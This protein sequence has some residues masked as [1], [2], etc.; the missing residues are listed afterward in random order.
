MWLDKVKKA[1]GDNLN[2]TWKNFSLEQNAHNLKEG[3]DSDWKVWEQ[4][5]ASERR[6][7][8]SQIAAEAAR[9]QGE[10]AHA[11]FHLALLVARH[12]GEGRISLSDE[13]AIL[14]LAESVGLDSAQM[15]EDMKDP[16]LRR[17]IGEEHEAAISE[18]IFGTPTYVFENGNMAYLKAFIPDDEDAVASFEHYIALANHRNYFGEIKRP[19][20]PW[21][22]G[23]LS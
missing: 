4:E 15:R 23:V 13:D 2:I 22:K 17:K 19:Q 14:E 6:S 21:P 11:K 1:Y 10:E 12:G 8:V 9:R 18:G 16:E 20:P 3:L 5:D 7:L